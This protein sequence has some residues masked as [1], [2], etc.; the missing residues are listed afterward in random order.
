MCREASL[1]LFRTTELWEMFKYDTADEVM[2]T[3]DDV[4][5]GD[6]KK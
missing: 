4:V 2:K 6:R 3:I 5:K 1:T